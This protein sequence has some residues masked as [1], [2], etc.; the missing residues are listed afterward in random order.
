MKLQK[1]NGRKFCGFI[2]SL[3]LPFISYK[4]AKPIKEET[5]EFNYLEIKNFYPL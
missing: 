2:I 3:N 4:T 5:N 1:E